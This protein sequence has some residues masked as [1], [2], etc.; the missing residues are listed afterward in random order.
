VRGALIQ[1]AIVSVVYFALIEL[2]SRSK[3][4]KLLVNVLLTIFFFMLFSVF[5]YFWQGYIYKRRER[6]RV[7]G[8]K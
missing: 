8:K 1:A 5:T 4:T 2:L 3:G 7:E 6:A